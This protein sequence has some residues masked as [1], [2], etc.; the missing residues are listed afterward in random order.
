[1]GARPARVSGDGDRVKH[2][3]MSIARRLVFCDTHGMRY[4][5]PISPLGPTLTRPELRVIERLPWTFG[6]L[7]EAREDCEHYVYS[8]MDGVACA[9]CSGWYCA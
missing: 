1:M 3:T 9:W 2:E 6:V 7:Y 4:V 5:D 8:K